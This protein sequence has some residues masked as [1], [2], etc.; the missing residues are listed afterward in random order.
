[1]HGWPQKYSNLKRIEEKTSCGVKSVFS[2]NSNS[3]LPSIPVS[4]FFL[5]L[6]DY[7]DKWICL[8]YFEF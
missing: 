4:R 2:R 8:K 7:N 3:S 1:M 5:I 6:A